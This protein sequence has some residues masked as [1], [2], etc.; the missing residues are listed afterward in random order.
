MTKAKQ[1]LG[2]AL[3]L[4]TVL[5]LLPMWAGAALPA[6]PEATNKIESD[7]LEAFTTEGTADFIV[8][9][10]EQP[11]LSPAYSMDWD[12]RGEFVY[13]TLRTAAEHSQARAKADLD[14]RGV[15]YRSFIAGNELYVW[16]GDLA[17]A[18]RLSELSEV[19]SIQATR[20]YDIEPINP[21]EAS[22]IEWNIQDT[23]AMDFWSTFGVHG[24]GIRV[25]SISTGVYPNHPALHP[26]Y[27]CGSDYT[28]PACWE[29]PSNICGGTM[30]DNHGLGSHV[31]GI[32][33]GD[34]GGANQIGMAPDATWIA[35]K[36]CESSSCTTSAL[37][38]C[39]DWILAPG[40]DPANRP[41]V[42]ASSWGGGGCN[43]WYLAKVQAWRAAGTFATFPSGNS[44]PGCSSLGSPA[45]YQE[46]FTSA[47]HDSSRN[48]PG[49]SSRGPSCFGHEPF[50]KP[51]IS[52]PG[53]NIRS[54]WNDGGYKTSSG[55]NMASP[56]SAGAV[57]LLWSCNPAMVGQIDRTFE[58]LHRTA[59]P[60]P[61]GNCGAPP[62][63]E[64]NYTYGYGHLNV[65]AAGQA[66]CGGTWLPGTPDPFDLNRYDCAWFDDGS[67]LSN[68]NRKVYCMGGRTGSAT[69]SPDIWRYD[70][71]A[72]TWQD[73]GHDMIEDVSNY[74]ANVLRDGD[75]WAIY[76][77]SGYD[78]ETWSHTTYV[79]RYY[80][81]TGVVGN[82]A[83]DPWPLT[84][85]GTTAYPGGCITV[86][87]RIYC[88]GGFEVGAAPL[89]YSDQ[90][91]EYD[92]ARPAGSRWRRITTAD[93]HQPRAH[94]QLA[95][96][97]NVIY[98]MGGDYQYTGSDLVPSNMVEALDVSNLAVGWQLRAP[99]PV[100]SGEGRG[101]GWA[102]KVYVAGGGD[103]PGQSGEVME[104]NIASN[105]WDADFPN[106]ITPRRN[107]AG[108]LIP[109]YTADP[110]DGLPGMWVFGG[111]IGSDEPP[112]G[113]PEY[114]SLR[115]LE[116]YLPVMLKS[117]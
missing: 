102:G 29:D 74:T 79:Q 14:S 17:A 11:D 62:D 12:A 22:A 117:H 51:N 68:Y 81:A 78:A 95:M 59:A 98:A 93:L 75:G 28:D 83:T 35:C 80:P 72:H 92:P 40:G 66:W 63:G 50:T 7:L 43:N 16:S 13:K 54:A 41:H 21:A 31:T 23:G 8:R 3:G 85:G 5:G 97:N 39:A 64:G 42:V 82:V 96:Q 67:G 76:V 24:E 109:L 6:D 87:N 112:F 88:V 46:S 45:D 52:A 89:Y 113:E 44:G 20:T 100:A 53:V 18:S 32:M 30:C 47:A 27:A 101:F 57:A 90:T 38:A 71:V 56:H 36:G 99:M 55:T 10:V 116:V 37:N 108:V 70:P 58:V 94:L 103:W 48:V 110:H 26:H 4:A 73:T 114:F 84:I 9:F 61:A 91:W 69:E 1:I 107:H 33:V 115:R 15:Q 19:A 2:L 105:T 77:V 106:L 34:D 104:Y 111:R 86:Q 65:L 49:F 25:A 60:G